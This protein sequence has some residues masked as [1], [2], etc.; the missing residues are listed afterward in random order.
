MKVEFW[1]KTTPDEKPGISVARHV[2]NVGHVARFLAETAP[3][4]LGIQ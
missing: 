2:A 3:R 4:L 1:A